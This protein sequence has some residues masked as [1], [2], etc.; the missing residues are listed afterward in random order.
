M[1]WS[2]EVSSLG[3]ERSTSLTGTI[4]N[5][6][7][8][9][10][11]ILLGLILSL[12]GGIRSRFSL[13]QQMFTSWR[14]HLAV[15]LSCSSLKALQIPRT[16]QKYGPISLLLS[17]APAHRPPMGLLSCPPCQP[18]HPARPS[19]HWWGW[20]CEGDEPSISGLTSTCRTCP[21]GARLPDHVCKAYHRQTVPAAMQMVG[22]QTVST[23][24]AILNNSRG[25]AACDPHSGAA[26][27]SGWDKQVWKGCQMPTGSLP[28]AIHSCLPS[29]HP[30]LCA[31][32][33]C[34]LSAHLRDIS[35]ARGSTVPV[36]APILTPRASSH[37]AKG[38]VPLPCFHC[39]QAQP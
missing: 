11:R 33:Q 39:P 23:A 35:P 20:P 24:M 8:L 19:G 15:A 18:C 17:W 4:L 14:I 31:F 5:F 12:V 37:R 1:C 7:N 2:R 29:V 34:S 16:A 30:A 26:Q 9:I 25:K 13:Q 38:H 36:L 10:F 3:Q 27:P 21:Q 32:P 6:P 22:W 28:Q